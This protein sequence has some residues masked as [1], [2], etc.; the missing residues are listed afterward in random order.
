M[1]SNYSR[2]D[3]GQRCVLKTKN[4]KVFTKYTLVCIMSSKGIVGYELYENGGMNV[5]RMIEFINKYI[6]KLRKKLKRQEM[7]YYIMFHINQKPM[8]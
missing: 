4:N 1:P 2:C 3:L 5:V 6:K 8:L 7:N